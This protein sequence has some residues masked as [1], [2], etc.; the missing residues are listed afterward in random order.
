MLRKLGW[1]AVLTAIFLCSAYLWLT[2][3]W[4]MLIVLAV[5]LIV[6]AILPRH[7]SDVELEELEREFSRELARKAFHFKR[8]PE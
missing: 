4:V 1:T 8:Y 3:F 5:F 7:L 6:W 2:Y